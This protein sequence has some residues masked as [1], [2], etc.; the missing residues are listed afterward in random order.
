MW[1]LNSQTALQEKEIPTTFMAMLLVSTFFSCKKKEETSTLHL[2]SRLISYVKV[3]TINTS[4]SCFFFNS[5]FLLWVLSVFRMAEPYVRHV[6]LLGFEKRFY[7]S[8]HYVSKVY[9]FCNMIQYLAQATSSYGFD[10]DE[11]TLCCLFME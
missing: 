1:C 2:P 5:S 9:Y 3:N 8:Q 6:E 11:L 7:P 10:E 4:M